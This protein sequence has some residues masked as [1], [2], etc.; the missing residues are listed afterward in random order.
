MKSAGCDCHLLLRSQPYIE[1]TRAE[2]ERVE[3]SESIYPKAHIT[4][5]IHDR[6]LAESLAAKVGHQNGIRY[7]TTGGLADNTHA[8]SRDRMAAPRKNAHGHSQPRGGPTFVTILWPAPLSAWRRLHTIESTVR[9]SPV[10]GCFRE[11]SLR[12]LSHF[13]SRVWPAWSLTLLQRI[14]WILR[15]KEHWSVALQKL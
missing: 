10:N 14:P 4:N 9:E 15:Y 2:H 7:G 8:V 11:R 1:K 12:F 3:R 13:S 6:V 5:K